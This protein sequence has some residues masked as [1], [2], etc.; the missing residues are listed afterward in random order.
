M[1]HPLK[2]PLFLAS[3][4]LFLLHQLLQQVWHHSI[5]LA[6]AY[7]DNL[8]AMPI[9]LSL[10]LAERRHL[11]GRGT[12]YFLS[13]TEVW[14]TTAYIGVIAEFIFPH[15]SR[16]FTYDPLDFLFYAAGTG[17]FLLS[18]KGRRKTQPKEH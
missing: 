5:P 14:L 10:L 8:L 12:N 7:L 16:Q 4:F 2:T 1:T 3:S 9:I 11:F 15:F 17:L 18:E 13:S 6:D